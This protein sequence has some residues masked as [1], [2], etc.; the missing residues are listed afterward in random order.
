MKHLH[1]ICHA[2]T[3]FRDC[4]YVTKKGVCVFYTRRSGRCEMLAKY[5]SD[6]H[7]PARSMSVRSV[8]RRS[9]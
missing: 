6:F 3:V 7:P 1:N 8:E 5:F 2:K 4:I 9:R